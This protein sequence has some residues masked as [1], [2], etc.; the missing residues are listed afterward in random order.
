MV[1]GKLCEIGRGSARDFFNVGCDGTP[2]V[3][4]IDCVQF[5]YQLYLPRRHP[6]LKH[7]VARGGFRRIDVLKLTPRHLGKNQCYLGNPERRWTG[8]RLNFS[9]VPVTCQRLRGNTR[10]IARVDKAGRP[11]PPWQINRAIAWRKVGDEIL[12][13]RIRP[14]KRERYARFTDVF[15]ICAMPF[16]GRGLRRL[17]DANRR[18]F[19]NVTDAGALRRI[20]EHIHY[21]QLIWQQ[22]RQKRNFLDT[23]E[24]TGKCFLVFKV[25]W[26]ECNVCVELFSRPG[27]IANPRRAQLR[28]S[29]KVASRHRARSCRSRQLPKQVCALISVIFR[30]EIAQEPGA[31]RREGD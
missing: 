11:I 17:I 9:F 24:R 23:F 3:L 20:D 4:L 19:H 30:E 26:H 21:L 14:Q 2:A 25:E 8:Q 27:F 15:F 29:R 31:G 16:Y 13:E 6:R 12:H 7:S 18:K 1:A 5:H 28:P 10:D 22:R